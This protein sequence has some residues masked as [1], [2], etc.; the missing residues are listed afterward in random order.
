VKSGGSYILFLENLS[1][2]EIYWATGSHYVTHWK[3]TEE[4]LVRRVLNFVICSRLV[5]RLSYDA[6]PA[7]KI[8][9]DNVRLPGMPPR[10]WPG[11]LELTPEDGLGLEWLVPKNELFAYLDRLAQTASNRD[12]NR[13]ER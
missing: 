11:A 5:P 9:D 2:R 1:L 7:S 8:V 10:Q 3:S 13:G 6:A 12:E 4:L